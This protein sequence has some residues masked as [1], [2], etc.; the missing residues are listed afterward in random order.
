MITL[1]SL[2]E[3]MWTKAKVGMWFVITF[4]VFKMNFRFSLKVLDS[5]HNSMQK[6]II[7]DDGLIVFILKKV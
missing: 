3:L 2:R 4:T 5:C 7:F 6:A 1:I